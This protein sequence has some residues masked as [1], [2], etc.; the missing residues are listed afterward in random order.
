M[1]IGKNQVIN[2]TYA[3]LDN[4]RR[5]VGE[6]FNRRSGPFKNGSDANLREVYGV[7][8]DVQNGVASAFGIGDLYAGARGLVSSRKA[9]EDQAV[10]LFGRNM[11]GSLVPKLRG[12]ATGLVSGD[13]SKFNQLINALPKNSRAEA[14]ATVLS[15][16]F[17]GG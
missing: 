17:S 9:L 13:I 12:A 16:I 10:A 4:I 5:N 14:A 7:L 3:T 11:S 2:P 1:N 6:G 15:E 8:S